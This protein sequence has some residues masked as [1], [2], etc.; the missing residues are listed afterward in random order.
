MSKEFRVLHRCG[1]C[2]IS[3]WLD[4]IN[5]VCFYCGGQIVNL[6]AAKVIAEVEYDHKEER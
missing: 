5:W 4:D 6:S 2:S 1:E 3:Y